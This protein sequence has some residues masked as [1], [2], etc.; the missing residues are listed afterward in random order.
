MTRTLLKAHKRIK[1]L[2]KII[3]LQDGKIGCLCVKAPY[4]CLPIEVPKNN[5][6]VKLPVGILL[7][8]DTTKLS[9][10]IKN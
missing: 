6:A 10:T 1:E 2:H 5:V 7:G 9:N 3:V 8:A 4:I